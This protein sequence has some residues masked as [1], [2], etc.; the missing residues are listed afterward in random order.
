MNSIEKLVYMANQIVRNIAPVA[1]DTAVKAL[2]DH[3]AHFWDPRM[4]QM[5]FA[6]IDAGGEGL[7][8]PALEGLKLL[9][10][11]GAPKSQTSVTQFANADGSGHFDA[12]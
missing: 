8:P 4:K 2:A 1:D 11:R 6:Y 9:K 5:I 3:I 7:L 10:D 12:G